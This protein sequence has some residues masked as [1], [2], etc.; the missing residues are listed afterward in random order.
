MAAGGRTLPLVL[1]ILVMSWACEPAPPP[2]DPELREALGID[3]GVPI[4]EILLS[5]RGDRT[6]LL[7]AHVEIRSGDVVQ[8]RVMDRRVHQV[9]F[10]LE[11]AAPALRSF[12][13]S[14][15]QVA[16]PPLVERDAR[17][18][19]DFTDAPEGRY[20]YVVEGYGEP[21]R[22]SIRVR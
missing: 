10:E 12:L 11:D 15:N 14:S 9:R 1:G 16:P 8:F 2:S 3:D 13:V 6:R 19:L 20:P 5:G 7:P 4:H 22:G 21:V 17:L 18:V